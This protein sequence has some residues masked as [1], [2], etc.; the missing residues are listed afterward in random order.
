MATFPLPKPKNKRTI[1]SLLKKIDSDDLQGLQKVFSKYDMT[2]YVPHLLIYTAEHGLEQCGLWLLDYAQKHKSE[3]P[4]RLSFYISCGGSVPLLQTYLSLTN[5]VPYLFK[6][7]SLGGKHLVGA[8]TQGHTDMMHFVLNY[9][10]SKTTITP[11]DKN[12]ALFWA[13]HNGHLG[14]VKM[15]V[16]VADPKAEQ[17]LALQWAFKNG[18]RDVIDFLVPLSDLKEAL[19]DMQKKWSK[20]PSIYLEIQAFEERR[21]IVKGLEDHPAYEEAL[22]DTKKKPSKKM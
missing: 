2:P 1:N 10:K 14:A 22:A 11:Q 13:S 5:T 20:D 18:N 12:L 16:D 21:L 17:S 7:Q 3:I 6:N 8:A 19:Y 9:K 15:L 4:A